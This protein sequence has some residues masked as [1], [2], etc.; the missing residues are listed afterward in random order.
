MIMFN[1]L[2]LGHSNDCSFAMALAFYTFIH[3]SQSIFKR[4]TICKTALPVASNLTTASDID[5][6]NSR[7]MAMNYC[8][9]LY[10]DLGGTL[11][12]LKLSRVGYVNDF[13]HNTHLNITIFMRYN[14]SN[15]II[16]STLSLIL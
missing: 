6:S 9:L 2:H 10:V 15:L 5:G 4:M 1:S 16:N 7:L 11:V 12:K 3:R 13:E 8:C 14:S